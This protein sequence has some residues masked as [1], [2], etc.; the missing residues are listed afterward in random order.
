MSL[1]LFSCKDEEDI[2]IVDFKGDWEVKWKQ[3]DIYYN[4]HQGGISFTFNDT[5]D[6]VGQ[7]KELQADTLFTTSFRFE[8]TDINTLLIDSIYTVGGNSQWLGTHQITDASTANFLL[9]RQ[10]QQC[11][12]ELY[13]FSR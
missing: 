7:V 11:K 12:N 10:N 6:N 4:Q 3:C 8:F 9:K 1:L 2:E 13:Q 5:T